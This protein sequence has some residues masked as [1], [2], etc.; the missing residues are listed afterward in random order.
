MSGRGGRRETREYADIA[1]PAEVLS[2]SSPVHIIYRRGREQEATAG[3]C[4]YRTPE[5]VHRHLRAIGISVH[6]QTVQYLQPTTTV[7]VG[8]GVWHTSRCSSAGTGSPL[9]RGS[10]KT[11]TDGDSQLSPQGDEGSAQP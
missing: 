10:L 11:W 4:V 9:N 8:G 3:T 1:R 6:T 5:L 7:R 2:E